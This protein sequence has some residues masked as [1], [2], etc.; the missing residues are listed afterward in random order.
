[1][2]TQI[3][4]H[5][6]EAST[7]VVAHWQTYPGSFPGL[8]WRE[9]TLPCGD[10]RLGESMLVERKSAADFNLAIMDRRLYGE[11]LALRAAADQVVY[12]VE[13]DFFAGRFHSDAALS[14]EAIA[15][16]T[17]VE[18]VSLVP[19]YSPAFTAEIVYSMARLVQHG[20]GQLPVLRKGKPFDPRGSQQYVVE[21]LP[22]VSPPLAQALLAKFGNVAA[23][24]AASADEL[25]E[26]SGMSAQLAQ[27]IRK[28]LDLPWA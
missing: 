20:F 1:M 3:L 6:R 24:Y 11:V 9:E 10:F 23:V 21:G 16:M 28:V 5:P 26:V 15:W 22:G 18:G 2:I 19:S 13:G 8:E 14:N 27:R 4:L 25:A 12:L 17:A 7:P